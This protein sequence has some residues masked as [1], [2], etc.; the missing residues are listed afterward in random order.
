MEA[1]AS[2]YEVSETTFNHVWKACGLLRFLFSFE[3]GVTKVLAVAKHADRVSERGTTS[4]EG[5]FR[6]AHALFCSNRFN[7][8]KIVQC[9]S[10]SG[11]Y[12]KI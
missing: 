8:C 3:Q 11:S 7:C 5:I 2:R 9:L 4:G 1:D 6:L 12:C 10:S